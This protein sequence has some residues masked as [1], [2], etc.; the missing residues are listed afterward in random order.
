[1]GCNNI[2]K[3]YCQRQNNICI[4]RNNQTEKFAFTK[5]QIINVFAQ[6]MQSTT[7]Q[8][9]THWASNALPNL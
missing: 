6:K 7:V 9:F 4:Q 1:M 8:N 3:I 2:I 5:V